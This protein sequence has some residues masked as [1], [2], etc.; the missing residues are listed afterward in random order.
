MVD[1]S[2]ILENV[3]FVSLWPFSLVLDKLERQGKGNDYKFHFKVTKLDH[4]Q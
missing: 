2:W 1:D 3:V 4:F